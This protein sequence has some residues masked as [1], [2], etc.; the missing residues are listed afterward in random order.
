MIEMEMQTNSWDSDGEEFVPHSR[1][2]DYI[3]RAAR[4][5]NVDKY[6]IFGTRVNRVRKAGEKWTI[7]STQI[8]RCDGKSS[9]EQR[10]E[11]RNMP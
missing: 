3:Q 11:V 1:L 6:T 10:D 8:S 2:A 4:K 5:Y 7:Q 9:I